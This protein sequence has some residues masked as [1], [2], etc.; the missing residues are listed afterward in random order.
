M[1]NGQRGGQQG[2]YVLHM[3]PWQNCFLSNKTFQLC[4]IFT[5]IY[6]NILVV[7]HP[8]RAFTY[9]GHQCLRFELMLTLTA[10]F[11][12]RI[13]SRLLSFARVLWNPGRLYLR[14][15]NECLVGFVKI[16][17]RKKCSFLKGEK[18][19]TSEE[20]LV[21][22]LTFECKKSGLQQRTN[23]KRPKFF[24]ECEC[25]LPSWRHPPCMHTYVF[26]S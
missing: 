26:L 2:T 17:S 6:I 19:V 13:M 10:G 11:F 1:K 15:Y 8:C 7:L 23:F 21:L 3:W 18:N 16:L 9:L 22:G 14:T 12:D 20:I 4:S 25:S 24:Y 5:F